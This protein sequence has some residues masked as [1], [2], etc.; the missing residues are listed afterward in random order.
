MRA[1]IDF[2]GVTVNRGTGDFNASSLAH[3][4]NTETVN[5]LVVES[6]LDRAGTDSCCNESPDYKL[7]R[8]GSNSE[9]NTDFLC[10]SC[11]CSRSDSRLSVGWYRC[12]LY[13]FKYESTRS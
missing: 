9:I 13:T 1:N 10:K 5:T 7:I 12:S 2:E 3:V 6:W 4:V 8:K 11:S